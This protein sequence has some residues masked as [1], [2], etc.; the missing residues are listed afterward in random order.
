MP[1]FER[2]ERCPQLEH[3]TKYVRDM[4]KTGMKKRVNLEARSSRCCFA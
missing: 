2:D 1:L 3:V 4:V